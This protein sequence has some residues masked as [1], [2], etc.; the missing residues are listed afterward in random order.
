[1]FFSETRVDQVSR[2]GKGIFLQNNCSALSDLDLGL[3]LD[4]DLG[5][6]GLDFEVDELAGD[7]NGRAFIEEEEG[8]GE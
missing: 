1:M 6:E 8:K 5:L 7:R 4:L 2:E 3:D